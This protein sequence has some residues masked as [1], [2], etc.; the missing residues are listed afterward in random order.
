MGK[1]SDYSRVKVIDVWLESRR[2]KLL[3]QALSRSS[4]E[5]YYL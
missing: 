3:S 5:Y 2:L 4:H 1:K